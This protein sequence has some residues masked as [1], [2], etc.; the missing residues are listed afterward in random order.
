[1]KVR[2]RNN[3]L[4]LE[5]HCTNLDEATEDKVKEIAAKYQIAW[6]KR[7]PEEMP[8]ISKGRTIMRTIERVVPK[9]KKQMIDE[10]KKILTITMFIPREYWT[11]E[12]EEAFNSND[13]INEKDIVREN[14]VKDRYGIRIVLSPFEETSDTLRRARMVADVTEMQWE[15]IK[16]LFNYKYE[17]IKDEEGRLIGKKKNYVHRIVVDEMI[18]ESDDDKVRLEETAKVK[19]A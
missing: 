5:G 15:Y 13:L 14:E 10:I 17:R 2:I 16:E 6:D 9:S 12:Q 7:V 19:K 4:A 18:P 11:P 8:V 3:R 1:M